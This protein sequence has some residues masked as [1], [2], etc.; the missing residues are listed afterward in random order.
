WRCRLQPPP[1]LRDGLWP[2]RGIF[3]QTC[4]N[5]FFPILWNRISFDF[6][7]LAPLRHRGRNLFSDLSIDVA[8]IERR[9]TCEQFING[10]AE[11]VDVVEMSAAFALEVLGA[12]VNQRA[13]R[14]AR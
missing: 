10:R 4:G 14:G 11:R 7:I 12:H 6:E 13:A 9:L 8:R 2:L 3:C 1:N 5:S